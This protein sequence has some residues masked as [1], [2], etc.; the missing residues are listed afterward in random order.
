MCDRLKAAKE[1][2]DKLELRA[3]IRPHHS[4]SMRFVNLGDEQELEKDIHKKMKHIN[5]GSISK[6]DP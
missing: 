4:Q 6:A 2:M 3:E 1:L 5:L